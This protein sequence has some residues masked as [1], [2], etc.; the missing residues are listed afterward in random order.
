MWGSRSFLGMEIKDDYVKIV[1][2]SRRNRGVQLEHFVYERLPQGWIEGGR[3]KKPVELAEFLHRVAKDEMLRKRKV[4]VS[5]ASPHFRLRKKVYPYMSQRLLKKVIAH[6]VHEQMALPYD[7]PLYD[8]A[9]LQRP[10][11]RDENN[12]WKLLLAIASRAFVRDYVEVVRASRLRPVGVD[13]APLAVYRWL[14]YV[15]PDQSEVQSVLVVN[16]S[17]RVAEVALFAQDVPVLSRRLTVNVA[18]H[19]VAADLRTQLVAQASG[20]VVG[21][22]GSEKPVHT[23]SCA[24]EEEAACTSEWI[25]GEEDGHPTGSTRGD[26]TRH[27]KKSGN[28]TYLSQAGVTVKDRALVTAYADEL[29]ALLE[30][31]VT[32]YDLDLATEVVLTGDELPLYPL[33]H[34][35]Q[36]RLAHRVTVLSE[37]IPVSD[38]LLYKPPTGV[39]N[40]LCVSMG[41]ALQG[42]V[43][44]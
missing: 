13:L 22:I 27:T 26:G 2:M 9:Y 10:R 23:S 38:S 15:R 32:L 24:H 31:M 4:H 42:L 30:Q 7:D 14:K 18:D 20:K 19:V 39:K 17:K 16:V 1:E 5:I 28:V 40:G 8:V 29:A 44:T 12:E 25:D 36:E 11:K 33:S 41:L 21:R 34:L 43:R 6:D 35:L 3:I 37:E